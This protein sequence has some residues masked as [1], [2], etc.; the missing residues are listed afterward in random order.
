MNWGIRLL[1][2]SL[3][4]KDKLLEKPFLLLGGMVVGGVAATWVSVTTSFQLKDSSGEPYLVLQDKL[5]S[6]YPGLLTAVVIVFCWW[7]MAKKNISPIKVMLLLVII[8]FIGVV[9]G[10]FNPG[11][12]Y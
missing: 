10:F 11:L 5:D 3:E 4:L 8:A 2:F 6:V 7:L 1:S 9:T 12:S